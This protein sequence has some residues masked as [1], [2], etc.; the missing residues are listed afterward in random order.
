MAANTPVPTH[1]SFPVIAT[2]ALSGLSLTHI[3]AAASLVVI[4]L[5]AYAALLRC[6]R[7]RRALRADREKCR[8]CREKSLES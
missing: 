8:A 3:N 6:Q 2:G 1:E 4:G 7:E 5:S